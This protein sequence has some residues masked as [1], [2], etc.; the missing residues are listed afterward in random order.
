MM[1]R[2]NRVIYSS[3]RFEEIMQSREGLL[4]PSTSELIRTM[5]DRYDRLMRE[6][7]PQLSAEE[8]SVVFNALREKVARH[9][10]IEEPINLVIDW[11]QEQGKSVAQY[12]ELIEKLRNFGPIENVALID[13]IERKLN[14][15]PEQVA[16]IVSVS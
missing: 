3:D 6:Y 8:F 4:Y 11:I 10:Q 15:A 16:Q 13:L 7:E 5:L 9:Q 12:Q 2:R 14:A 1:R